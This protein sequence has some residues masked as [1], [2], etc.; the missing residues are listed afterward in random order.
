[1]YRKITGLCGNIHLFY[2]TLNIFHFGPSTARVYA[3]RKRATWCWQ[4]CNHKIQIYY[5]TCID[6]LV[7]VR[8][9]GYTNIPCSRHKG[10]S[11]PIVNIRIHVWSTIS[12]PQYPQLRRDVCSQALS[13]RTGHI[14]PYSSWFICLLRFH[15]WCFLWLL[16]I[17][18]CHRLDSL[19]GST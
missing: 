6:Q 14:P 18:W 13:E 12:E 17:Q 5:N 3:E 1:M 4:I 8:I 11:L 16:S 9:Y 7:E 10:R 2:K 19:L 15:W